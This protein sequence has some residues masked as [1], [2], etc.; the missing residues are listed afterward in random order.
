M[1]SIPERLKAARRL[2]SEEDYEQFE[3]ALAEI[4]PAADLALLPALY[5]V[6]DDETKLLDLMWQ[7]LHLVEDFEEEAGLLALIEKT[8]YLQEHAPKWLNILWARTLN[9]DEALTRLKYEI[10][11]L[12]DTTSIADYLRSEPSLQP[13]A[14]R[15]FSAR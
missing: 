12:I 1:M 5:E 7:L 9:S 13:K 4:N 15:L 2:Q 11:P 3:D 10:F 8:P 6:F 14:A